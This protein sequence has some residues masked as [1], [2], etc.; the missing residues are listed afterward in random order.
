MRL[1][2]V[3]PNYNHQDA[4]AQ[5][6][7]QLAQLEL[8]C[9]LIDDGSNGETQQL[10]SQLE[11][12][13]SW[14]TLIRHPYNR[15]K[16][17]AVM[18]GLR[19]AYQDGYT[20]ALQI[21]AD[22][23][24]NLADIPAMI[25]AA[26]NHPEAVISGKPI[27]DE[28]IPKGRLYGRYITHFWVWVETLSFEIQDSMCGFRV[29]PLAATEALLSQELLTERMDFDIEILVKLYWQGC[30]VIHVPTKVIYPEGGISH[31]Q[32]LKDNLRISALHTRLF[33]GMLARIPKL[34]IRRKHTAEHWSNIKERG[35]YWGIKLLASS[36]RIGGYGLCRA[37]M[38][39]VICYFF[40]TGRQAR[41]ASQDF[42]QTVKQ[43]EPNHPDLSTTLSWRDGLQHFLSFGHAALDRMD[44]WCNRIKL[45]QVEYP[46]RHLLLNLLEQKQGAVILV[47]HLG[48][49]ELC[50]AIS[51]NQS[52]FKINVMVLTKHAENFNKVLTQLNPNS[53]LN[54]IQVTDLGPS[55]SILLKQKIE[56]G[57]LVV[58]ACDRT[59]AST[60]ERVIYAPFMGRIAPFP[61]GPFILAGLLDCPVFSMFCLK[62]QGRY[63]VHLQHFSQTLKGPRQGRMQRLEQAVIE[64][65]QRLEHFAKAAPLQWFNFFDFWQQDASHDRHNSKSSNNE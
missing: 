21:D 51:V 15:G 6:L 64:Y 8:S 49:I 5:T 53:S 41:L 36:Y 62:Q 55:T 4:I 16:G 12:Q 42:L 28:S 18:T 22:G 29:Y 44:A 9:Y 38:Y 7:A 58:I 13:Y 47:S 59:S 26:Q 54:L 3:I 14:V 2:L 57:E 43:L 25:T 30:T 60:H 32:G 24:H 63:H 35:S 27:Y 10:L 23:Q 33:F 65:S 40:V 31:F 17:A 20:H 46:D 11:Q 1:A 37:I 50:R 61:Q 48:N 39:P 19:Q 56:Q 34:L 45:D 52:P